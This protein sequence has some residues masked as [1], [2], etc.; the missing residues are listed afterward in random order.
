MEDEIKTENADSVENTAKNTVEEPTNISEQDFIDRRLSGNANSEGKD[1]AVSEVQDEVQENE[2]KSEETDPNVLSQVAD[3]DNMSDKELKELSEKLGSRAVAR[4]GELTAKRKAAEEK[5]AQLE[6]QLSQRK[7]VNYSE[8]DIKNNPYKDIKD[9]A[10]LKAKAKELTDVIEWAEE[11]LFDSDSYSATDV[12]TSVDGQDLTK[13]DVRNALLNARKSKT[14]YLPMQYNQLKAEAQGVQL[15]KGFEQ[16]ARQE[17]T[18]MSED[19]S[20][21]K[22]KYDAM[23]RDPRLTNS[24]KSATP[25]LKAQMPYLLAHAANSLYGRKVLPQSST[26]A[27]Q[28]VPLDP[29]KVT[30]SAA[31]PA[32]SSAAK[33]KAIAYHSKFKNTGDANDFVKLRT[34]QLSNR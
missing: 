12:V 15:K 31:K 5:A 27:K 34:L 26:P 2:A 33:K 3:L 16:R 21:V 1:E 14:K 6:K 32:R 20:E 28:N 8:E 4:F 17:L 23:L 19:K 9:P 11:V 29:P 30:S 7:Q 13:K 10:K 22:A 24:L 25:E 18:W